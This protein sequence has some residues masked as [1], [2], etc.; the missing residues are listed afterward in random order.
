MTIRTAS[1][2]SLVLA[3]T[4]ACVA[5]LASE[6]L[7]ADLEVRIKGVKSAEGDVRVALHRHLPDADFPGEE[8]VVAATLRPAKA[9]TVRFV[10]TDVGPGAYAVAAFHD[11]DSD[12]ELATNFLGMPTEG[13]GFSNGA[14]GF[15]GPPSFNAAAFTVDAGQARLAVSVPMGY[16]QP[17]QQES[18]R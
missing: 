5:T 11:A 16:P 1:I 18:T 9:G 4:L 14:L 2:K 13:Y 15:L 12:G 7:A 6:A 8:S 17:K 10:F 3:T